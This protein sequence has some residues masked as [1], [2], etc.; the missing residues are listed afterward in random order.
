MKKN[1]D[2]YSLKLF[3]SE[4]KFLWEL[5]VFWKKR[6]NLEKIRTPK[7]PYPIMILPGFFTS[8]LSTSFLRKLLRQKGLACYGW[9]L[10]RNRGYHRHTLEKL[11]KRIE[12]LYR[13]HGVPVILIGWS[14]GGIYARELGRHYPDKIKKIITL[15]SPFYVPHRTPVDRLYRRSAGHDLQALNSLMKKH[16]K[17]DFPVPILAISAR[18]DGIVPW[19]T[20]TLFKNNRFK[21]FVAPSTHLGL[22]HNHSVTKKI[23]EELA[24]N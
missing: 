10:G 11:R 18:R 12:E 19:H 6:K 3:L 22:P 14:L 17:T 7:L 16:R 23:L 13:E 8:D 15:G 20:C 2:S 5:V 24:K 21:C 9:E 4:A 1:K